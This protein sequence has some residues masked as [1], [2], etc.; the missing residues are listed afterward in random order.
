VGDDKSGLAAGGSEVGKGVEVEELCKPGS[1]Q[2]ASTQAAGKGLQGV[3]A[4]A[5]QGLGGTEGFTR[6]S[7]GETHSIVSL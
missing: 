3:V 1:P 2:A 5:T 4:L 6:Q 7:K